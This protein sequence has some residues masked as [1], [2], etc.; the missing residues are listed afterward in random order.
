MIR[1][2]FL[3]TLV[4]GFACST[5]SGQEWATK[6]FETREHDFGTIARGAK[7]EFEFV[8]SN[9]YLEDVHVAS[10]RSS[11]GC[12]SVSIKNPLLKTYEKGAIV[13]AVN[14]RS[15]Y[16]RKGATITVT[17]DKPFY[18]EVQLH[19][20]SYIRSDVVVQPGSVQFGSVSQGSPAES[21]VAI[22]YAGRSDWRILEVRSADPNLSGEVVE[23]SRSNGE[24]TYELLVHLDS[25]APTG[26]LNDHLVLVTNDNNSMQV[27]VLVEGKIESSVAVSPTSLFMGIVQP[28]EK[29]T[30]PLVIRG[31][32]PFRVLSVHCDDSSFEFDTSGETQPKMIHVIPVTFVAGADAG[33]ISKL[34][35]VETDL[36]ESLPDLSAYAVVAP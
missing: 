36:G 14:S 25:D 7:A 34:I 31:A 32:K 16:G 30:R 5:S 27:P 18:A 29:V 13:A 10:V 12:T 8:L 24:V 11:C 4:V 26:Y 28:G 9:I 33:K 22:H 21:K 20:T 23:T 17:I 2:A 6:M 1:T 3:V 35:R 15:F 19:V